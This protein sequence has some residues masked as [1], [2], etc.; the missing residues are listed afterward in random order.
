MEPSAS[1]SVALRQATPR[2]IAAV[3]A[4][5]APSR[6][7]AEFKRY[8]DQVYAARSSGLQL[9]GQNIFIYHDAPDQPGQLDVD[10]G[11]GSPGSFA[12]VGNVRAV[13][14]PVGQVATT[15]HRG[16]YSDLRAAHDAVLA[17]CRSHSRA[18]AGPSWEIYGHWTDGEAPRTDVYYL[19]RPPAT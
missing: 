12:P 17:W 9:D 2:I 14:L 10:F 7:P 18:L 13:A 1:Y 6:V 3:R 19:L 8:L 15:T 5:L 4:R 16:A 11:V